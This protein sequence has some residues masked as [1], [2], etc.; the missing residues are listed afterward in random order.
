MKRVAMVV[1]GVV[2]IVGGL[3]GWYV[4]EARRRI[5]NKLAAAAIELP[6]LIDATDERLEQRY[7]DPLF[8]PPS[9]DDAGPVLNSRLEF[10]G[11]GKPSTPLLPE[12]CVELTRRF[13]SRNNAMPADELAACDTSFLTTLHRYGRW[14]LT[15]GPRESLPTGERTVYALP[16]LFPLQSMVKLHLEKAARAGTVEQAAVDVRHIV[17]LLFTN[18]YLV[19]AMFG[20]AM[21]AIEN[22]YTQRGF[23]SSDT[24]A[25]RARMFA[26]MYAH[27][28]LIA[29]WVPPQTRTPAPFLECIWLTEG[30]FMRR[31]VRLDAPGCDLSNARFELSH[32]WKQPDDEPFAAL[33]LPGRLGGKIAHALAPGWN[34]QLERHLEDADQLPPDGEWESVT[35]DSTL[36][37]LSK[38]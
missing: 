34:A 5:S 27:N 23:P 9:G 33:S 16:N 11:L 31:D 24:G 28:E 6:A 25:L 19:T 29:A 21:L 10:E 1:L 37:L 7:G 3:V 20:T 15:V 35:A 38:R 36:R 13:V 8:A 22:H 30:A 17:R 32:P 18:E 2:V 12:A 26:M 14:T 4:V